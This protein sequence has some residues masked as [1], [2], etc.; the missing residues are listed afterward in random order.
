MIKKARISVSLADLTHTMI[1]HAE[2]YAA[3]IIGTTTDNVD[4]LFIHSDLF[5]PDDS[6]LALGNEIKGNITR[7][8]YDQYRFL[9]DQME[10]SSSSS[11]SDCFSVYFED[12]DSPSNSDIEDASSPSDAEGC[13]SSSEADAK[14]S[15]S[16][17]IELPNLRNI[18]VDV[19]GK[20]LIIE[21]PGHAVGRVSVAMAPAWE[22][23][24]LHIDH[25]DCQQR[26]LLCLLGSGLKMWRA[27]LPY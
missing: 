11:D 7:I 17:P 21:D 25:E 8:F 3:A 1:E 20:E 5:P 18:L 16:P 19:L 6:L 2:H 26:R 22:L 9:Q 12:D 10:D 14:T 27:S 4:A 24:A 15:S 23:T 13:S